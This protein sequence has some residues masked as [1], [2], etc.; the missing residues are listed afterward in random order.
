MS[1]LKEMPAPSDQP[2]QNQIA[3][4]RKARA[5]ELFS[6]IQGSAPLQSKSSLEIGYAAYRLKEENLFGI[7]GFANEDEAREATG[8]GSSTW[9]STIKLAES[10]KDLPEELFVSMKLSNAYSLAD[11]PES[12]RLDRDWVKKAE[13]MPIKEFSKLVDEEM[14]GK[15]RASAGKERS[16]SLKLD[17]PASRKQVI[18]EKA[19]DF[20]EAHGM[21]TGDVGKVIEV[22][23]V[24]AT[25]GDTMV[26][27][28]LHVVQRAKRFK[29]LAESGLSSDEVLAEAIKL[30][31][32]NIL[33]LAAVLEVK[34]EGEEAA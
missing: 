27:A 23:L 8:V 2:N 9:Y 4:E 22:A 25:G 29:E 31:E 1:N 19:K 15:A 18:E 21:D 6:K 30:N 16:V 12:K 3:E 14:N 32:E 28:I 13:E 10:F 26:G 11:L 5:R 17:M 34:T 33:E 20:A 24:E 7:L